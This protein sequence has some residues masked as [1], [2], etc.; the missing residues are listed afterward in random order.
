MGA[1]GGGEASACGPWRPVEET[2]RGNGQRLAR[3][4]Y[5]VAVAGRIQ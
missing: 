5:Q 4:G 1:V 3:R 2:G